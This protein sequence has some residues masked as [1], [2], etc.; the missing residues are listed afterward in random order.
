MPRVFADADQVVVGA[1]LR[2]DTHLLDA[3]DVADFLARH[4]RRLDRALR[5]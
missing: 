5:Q 2:K 1:L 4:Q 3:R